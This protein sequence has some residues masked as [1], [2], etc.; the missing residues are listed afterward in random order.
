MTG[1][2][3]PS[4]LINLCGLYIATLEGNE[5]IEKKG[6]EVKKVS[7]KKE[8]G[9]LEKSNMQHFFYNIDCFPKFSASCS[10]LFTQIQ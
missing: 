1:K 4:C 2:L 9:C 8:N 6:R 3:D 7:S 5:A 10:Y